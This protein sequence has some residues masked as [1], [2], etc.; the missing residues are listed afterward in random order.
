[1][2]AVLLLTLLMMALRGAGDSLTPL[3]FMILAVALDSGLNPIFILGLGPAPRL[4][5]AGSASATLIANYVSLIGLLIYMYARDIPLRLRG[6]ELALSRPR[7]RRSFGPSSPR[8]C[9][10]ASR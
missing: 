4:G 8:A 7:S 1:M 6:S 10:W 9:R 3:W 2:P 5:I